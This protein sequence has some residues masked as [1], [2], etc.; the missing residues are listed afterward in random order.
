MAAGL[1]R[2]DFIAT[3]TEV[4]A[5][6]IADAYTRFAPAP[7]SQVVVG[8]SGARNPYLLRRLTFHLQQQ[9][10]D[11]VK[12]CIHA[13]MGIDDKAKEAVAFALLA[14]LTIHGWP[15]N[16]PACTGAHS[17]QILGQIAPGSNYSKSDRQVGIRPKHGAIL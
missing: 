8:G 10:S 17:R 4:T 9:L 12:L 6:S 1:S 13:A 14:Y 16:V 2:V 11:T 15:G 7:V 3:M 5:I